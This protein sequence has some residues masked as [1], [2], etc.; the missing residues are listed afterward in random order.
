LDDAFGMAPRQ[1]TEDHNATPYAN[2]HIPS[3]LAI[4]VSDASSALQICINGKDLTAHAL[5]NDVF[6][7]TKP[8]LVQDTPQSI[9]MKVPPKMGIRDV[10]DIVGHKYPISVIDVQHQEELEGWTLGDLVEYFEDEERLLRMK[11]SNHKSSR[12]QRRTATTTSKLQQPKVLNQI[13]MEFSKTPLSKY[14]KSPQFVRDLDWIDHAWP[15]G[16]PHDAPTVQ[17][18]CLTS[19][20]GCYTDFHVDFG[21]TSVWYHV[22]EGSKEFI[23]IE[24]TDENLRIYEE[25][26]C[27]SNQSQVWLCDMMPETPVK[28]QLQEGQT[29]VIPSGWIHAVYTPRDSLVFGGNFL[30]GLEIQKQL[31]INNLETRTRVP[32][33]FRFPSYLELQ[34][35]VAGM[36]LE[37][38]KTGTV[39]QSE[40]DGLKTLLYALKEWWKLQASPLMVTAAIGAA[41][42]CDC[43][44]VE[45]MIE[46]LEKERD[47]ILRDGIC[48]NPSY[49]DKPKLK[50]TTGIASPS[51]KVES[52]GFRITLPSSSLY[53]MPNRKVSRRE[54]IDEFFPVPNEGLE[55]WKPSKTLTS[56]ASKLA[57]KKETAAL[58]VAKVKIPIKVKKSTNSRDRLMK[59]FR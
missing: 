23:L 4:P 38:M 47:R 32:E 46:A 51:M 27:Q 6:N 5:K 15:K 48:R 7:P 13:S 25:W 45:Q 24:P 50:L 2:H 57:K 16:R 9:G 10:A 55:E 59:R 28:I 42:E 40:V 41:K 35:Y 14:I 52:T 44:S 8:I 30:H 18:Y 22:L 54:D 56:T 20:A 49:R 36:Y 58:P 34:F 19:T 12:R 1:R 33:K 37:S 31:S 11:Q 17:Y 21:G 53:P 43:E 3:F 26:L 39:C 29:L